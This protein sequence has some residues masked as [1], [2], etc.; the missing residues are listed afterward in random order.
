ME[1]IN[2]ILNRTVAGLPEPNKDKSE[3]LPAEDSEPGKSS[4]DATPRGKGNETAK[5]I[6]TELR[7]EW[8]RRRFNLNAL[9]PGVQTMVDACERWCRNV[10]RNGL[11]SRSIVLCGDFGCGKTECLAASAR[12]VRD[13]RMAIWPEPWPMPLTVM[14]VSWAQVVRE[15]TERDNP[16]FM[17]DLREANVL[18]LDD[19]GSEEDRYRSGSPTRILG[20]LLDDLHRKI[21]FVF[22]TTNI[23]PEGWRERWDGRVEDRLLRLDAEI[24]NLWECGVESY[25]SR[26]M[27]E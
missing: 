2:T 16:E 15:L 7:T 10:A 20:D 6:R 19:V 11:E 18:L 17:D 23:A 5:P 4:A 9:E 3:Y 22:I 21:R 24:M 13:V 8:Q 14:S 26:K 25:A 1:H 12:Y 27:R